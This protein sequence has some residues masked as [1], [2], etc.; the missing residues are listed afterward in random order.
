[1]FLTTG[2]QVLVKCDKVKKLAA[3]YTE[4]DGTFRAELPSDGPIST[5][6]VNC[7]AKIMRGPHQLYVSAKDSLIPIAKAKE[8]GHLFTTSRPLSFYSWCPSKGKCGA[9]D[10]GF[11]SSKTV[12]LPLPREW[13]LAPSSYYIPF[14]PIIGIPWRNMF[15]LFVKCLFTCYVWSPKRRVVGGVCFIYLQISCLVCRM[16]CRYRNVLRYH[17]VCVFQV[18][19][20]QNQRSMFLFLWVLLFANRLC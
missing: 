7:M 17:E 12:D 3:A 15:N 9:R 5:K 19:V 4:A 14:I 2:V 1:M 18:F 11:A 6:P 10:T 20:S 13:G 16:C 8:A